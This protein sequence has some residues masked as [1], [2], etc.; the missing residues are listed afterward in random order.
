MRVVSLVH[1]AIPQKTKLAPS[2]PIYYLLLR[3]N[4]ISVWRFG[5]LYNL[6]KLY[7]ISRV[8]EVSLVHFESSCIANL[9]SLTPIL[10]SLFR[11]K[12]ELFRMEIFQTTLI[13]L[14]SKHIYY[15]ISIES[16]VNLVHF[17]I[18]PISHL[19]PSEP[20]WL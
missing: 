2:G 13:S 20:I 15:A 14:I 10:L 1:L 19:P 12:Y 9:V 7:P 8:R 3:S 17:A 5:W 11:I 18:P 6:I 16:V 4:N